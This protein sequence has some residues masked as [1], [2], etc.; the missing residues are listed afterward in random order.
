MIAI[1]AGNR[2]QKLEL[3]ADRVPDQVLLAIW[4]RIL[5][6]PSLPGMAVTVK[7]LVRQHKLV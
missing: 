3:N 6:P 7:T 4:V 2:P 5:I 1:P